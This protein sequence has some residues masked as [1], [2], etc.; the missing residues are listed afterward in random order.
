MKKKKG[1]MDGMGL[2]DPDYAPAKQPSSRTF[3]LGTASNALVTP[4][5]V[6]FVVEARAVLP[7]SEVKITNGCKWSLCRPR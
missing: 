4:G 5:L 1:E 7:S 2:L 6:G 3:S